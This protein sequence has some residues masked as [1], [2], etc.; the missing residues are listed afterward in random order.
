MP[1]RATP[2]RPGQLPRG[3]S[4]RLQLASTRGGAADH[5]AADPRGEAMNRRTFEMVVLIVILMQP[6]LG[7]VRIWAHKQLVTNPPGSLMHA[8][9]EDVTLTVQR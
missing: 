2:P 7:I 5:Q 6:A 3:R 4:L 9:G 1:Q 8:V